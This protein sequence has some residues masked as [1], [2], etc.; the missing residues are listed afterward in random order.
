MVCK[1]RVR[2]DV[3][4]HKV[5]YCLERRDA[6]LET[7]MADVLCVYREV[8]VLRGSEARTSDVAIISYDEKPGIQAIANTAPD[9]PPKPRGASVNAGI[10]PLMASYMRGVEER[11]RSREF[12]AFL[13]LLEAACLADTSIK[14]ILR[15]HFEHVSKDTKA[16]LATQP[17]RRF[18]HVFTPKRVSWLNL[19]DGF[20]SKMAHS[21][22]RHIRVVT[23][24]PSGSR[25]WG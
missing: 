1:I 4:P 9:L 24:M 23:P 21:V 7:K 2:N 6:E 22:L 16:W 5:H 19:V 25:P 17:E 15:N 3:K 18:S 13:K 12:V 20:F 11:H 10:D 8:A 14:L